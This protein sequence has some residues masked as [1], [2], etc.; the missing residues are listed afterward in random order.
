MINEVFDKKCEQI[1][2]LADVLKKYSHPNNNKE[3]E[4]ELL[5]IKKSEI[6]F[7][8]YNLNF[9]F[10]KTDYDEY[11]LE[12][13]QIY[14][15]DFP[16]LPFDVPFKFAKTFYENMQDVSFLES[17]VD[18]IRVYCWMF[19]KKISDGSNLLPIKNYSK[20]FEEEGIRFFYIN[21]PFF[22]LLK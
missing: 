6:L 12:N 15:K 18:G 21:L 11:T 10:T 14:S 19:L 20:V 22:D 8:G 2:V 5:L 1:K 7:D 3:I 16:I 13:L 9:H 17:E 4:E